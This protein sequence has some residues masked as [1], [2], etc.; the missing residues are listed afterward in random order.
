MLDLLDS[1]FYINRLITLG[2][3]NE[4]EFGLHEKVNA[5]DE[6]LNGLIWLKEKTSNE[7]SANFLTEKIK[8]FETYRELSRL[9][10]KLMYFVD[11]DILKMG[12]EEGNNNSQESEF[13]AI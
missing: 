9:V 4:S 1:Q 6:N 5:I 3:A 10:E 8:K 2:F 7:V 13:G 12:I 11:H